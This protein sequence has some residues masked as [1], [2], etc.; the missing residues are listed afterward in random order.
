[1]NPD[2]ILAVQV[3]QGAGAPGEDLV[4]DEVLAASRVDAAE[5]DSLARPA[6]GHHPLRHRLE[7]GAVQQV[8]E[9]VGRGRAVADGGGRLAVEHAA[10]GNPHLDGAEIPGV[11][12]KAGVR[13]DLDR[14]I[15]ARFGRVEDA[16][17][18][19]RHL[20][21]GAREVE[22]D[23]V[24]P[25]ADRDLEAHRRL[26]D[27]V[28]VEEQLVLV[29]SIRHPRDRGAGPCLGV[30]EEGRGGGVDRTGAEALEGFLHPP[31]PH[32]VGGELGLDVAGSL[33]RGP[34]IEKNEREHV[35]RE[36]PPPCE[37]DRRDPQPF[38]EDAR[39]VRALAARNPSADVGVVGEAGHES[40]Q[41][42]L[43]EDRARGRQ[44]RQVRAP[45][46]VRVVG[47]EHVPRPQLVR[48][49]PAGEV[50]HHPQ[51]RPEM[52]GRRRPE[53]KRGAVRVEDGGRA[54]P[55]LLDV[56]RI[57]GLHQGGE[58]LF[59][60]RVEPMRDDLGR[61]EV[62]CGHGLPSDCRIGAPPDADQ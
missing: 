6:A 34:G 17:A 23:A 31:H 5:D 25:Y 46:D 47:E 16:V 14:L 32:R 53:R 56:G 54:V 52:N 18:R 38:L 58:H 2:R 3:E 8:A 13:D 9:H 26:P 7:Q 51:H 42:V 22:L 24:A 62:G 60:R 57:G 35:L 55:S 1:M 36:H 29:A 43:V 21:V 15:D 41:P 11:R 49:V 19:A 39:A 61:Q 48:R 45:A 37:P 4:V 50:V 33:V 12:R 40:H 44:V 27:A 59:G 20:W 30:V 10:G 28:V